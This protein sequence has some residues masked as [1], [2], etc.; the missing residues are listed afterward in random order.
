MP[1]KTTPTSW[2][3]AS[4]SGL[5]AQGNDITEIKT[6]INTH[7]SY[8][9]SQSSQYHNNLLN[10][11]YAFTQSESA[12]T[13]IRYDSINDIKKAINA[14]YYGATSAPYTDTTTSQAGSAMTAAAINDLRT[15]VNHVETNCVACDTCQFSTWSG[16]WSGNWSGNWSSNWSSNWSGQWSYQWSGQ[17]SSQW[18]GNW[19]SN[20][21]QCPQCPQCPNK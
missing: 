11:N 6:A 9:T 15:K 14:F 13:N 3:R 19:S 17:W 7:R 2:G 20:C 16:Q 5:V 1:K 18:S 8:I 4:L 12:G 10:G 21:N